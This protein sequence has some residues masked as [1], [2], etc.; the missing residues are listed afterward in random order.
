MHLDYYL[1]ECQHSR[2]NRRSS[3]S[4][5]KLFYQDVV[6]SGCGR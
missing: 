1:D 6:Q 4:R 3:R 2:L 5:A